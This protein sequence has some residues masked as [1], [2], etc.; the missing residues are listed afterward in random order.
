MAGVNRCSISI[1]DENSRVLKMIVNIVK[2][3]TKK[4]IENIK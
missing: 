1:G 2:L 3:A 4:K